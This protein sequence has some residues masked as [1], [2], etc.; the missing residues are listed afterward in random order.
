MRPVLLAIVLALNSGCYDPKSPNL[1]PCPK[2]AR[3]P[4]P[5]AVAL[6]RDAGK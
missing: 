2:D 3:W 4:D 5:C 1:P 6:A